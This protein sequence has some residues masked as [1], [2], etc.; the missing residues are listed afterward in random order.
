MWPTLK[1]KRMAELLV[2]ITMLTL[3][4]GA[5]TP[6]V[7]SEN[8]LEGDLLVNR[9]GSS[10]YADGSLVP[11]CNQPVSRC[12]PPGQGPPGLIAVA[13]PSSGFCLHR[14][15]RQVVDSQRTVSAVFFQAMLLM[16]SGRV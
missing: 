15:T 12:S 7:E 13:S 2:L 16:C 14:E 3:L 8:V 11:S 6:V 4:R 10:L 9:C 5:M 1:S